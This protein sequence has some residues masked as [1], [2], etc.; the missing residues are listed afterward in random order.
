VQDIGPPSSQGKLLARKQDSLPMTRE[1]R[2]QQNNYRP[3]ETAHLQGNQGS[4]INAENRDRRGSQQKTAQHLH[5]G[6]RPGNDNAAEP[7]PQLRPRLRQPRCHVSL[8]MHLP[9]RNLLA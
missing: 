1:I 7:E 3:T 5:K 9:R 6:R 2:R 8:Q 4:L